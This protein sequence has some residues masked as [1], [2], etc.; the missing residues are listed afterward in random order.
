MTMLTMMKL[1]KVVGN[2]RFDV[3]D[4]EL[5]VSLNIFN[6]ALT[7][8]AVCKSKSYKGA[9]LSYTHGKDDTGQHV[10]CA[11]PRRTQCELY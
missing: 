2:C 3:K 10:L 1:S 4:F 7:N 6:G 8:D 9:S 11:I 5:L